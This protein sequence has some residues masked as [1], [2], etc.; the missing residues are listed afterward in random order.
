MKDAIQE[1]YDALEKAYNDH[2]RTFARDIFEG[3]QTENEDETD[4]DF[5][6][7]LSESID[8]GGLMAYQRLADFAIIL[9]VSDSARDVIRENEYESPDSEACIASN[10]A[11]AYSRDIRQAI[12][13][14]REEASV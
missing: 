4:S 1:A 6:R 13:R 2:I 3:A 12:E 11:E 8:G 14:I 7:F 10:A 5:E 9:A